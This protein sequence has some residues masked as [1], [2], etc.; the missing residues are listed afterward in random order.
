MAVDIHSDYYRPETLAD[1]NNWEKSLWRQLMFLRSEYG[2]SRA[3][4]AKKLSMGESNLRRCEVSGTYGM[5]RMGAYAKNILRKRMI[6]DMSTGTVYLV[7]IDNP[8]WQVVGATSILEGRIS[9]P[10]DFEELSDEND[11]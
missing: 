1:Q 8:D 4:A 2:V 9:T 6:M 3:F 7:D 5:E 11:N 10:V